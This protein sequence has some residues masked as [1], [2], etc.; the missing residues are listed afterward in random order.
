MCGTHFGCKDIT[1]FIDI[2]KESYLLCDLAIH[3]FTI[4][5]YDMQRRGALRLYPYT[6]NETWWCGQDVDN[7]WTII[8]N[9]PRICVI[10]PYL[11]VFVPL[12]VDRDLF[13]V[14]AGRIRYLCDVFATEN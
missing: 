12:L 14:I 1:I 8:G 6:N 2:Q 5:C 11:G 9:S 3:S 7:V 13:F 10:R 4:P